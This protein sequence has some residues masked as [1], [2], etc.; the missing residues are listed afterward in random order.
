MISVPSRAA[1]TGTTTMARGLASRSER[2]GVSPQRTLLA[3]TRLSL[4]TARAGASMPTALL[5]RRSG[6]LRQPQPPLPPLPLQRRP[7]PQCGRTVAATKMPRCTRSRPS[8]PRLLEMTS[9]ASSARV[10]AGTPAINTSASRPA[11]SA[12]AASTCRVT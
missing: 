10:S 3:G 12:G 6:L 5:S 2:P 8:W 9:P 7:R 11:P 1:A 4:S